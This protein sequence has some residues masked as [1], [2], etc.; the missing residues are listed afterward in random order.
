MD[1][2]RVTLAD[3]RPELVFNQLTG[4]SN[5][6]YATYTPIRVAAAIAKGRLLEAAAIELGAA[7]EDLTARAGVISAGSGRSRTYGDLARKA[8]GI[9]IGTF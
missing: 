3:A 2:V 4:G 7:I 8:A 9:S 1:R 5:T 6:T